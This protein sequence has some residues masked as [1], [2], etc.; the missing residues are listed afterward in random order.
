MMGVLFGFLIAIVVGMT[1]A[2][3]GSLTVPVLVLGCGLPMGEAVGT[4]MVFVT[5]VKLLSAPAYVLR[6]QFSS[7]TLIQLLAGG[8]PGVVAGAL[9][10]TGLHTQ[11]LEQAVLAT[12]GGTMA[13]L[14]MASLWV[15]RRAGPWT[16]KRDRS[17]W[18][19]WV[20]LPIGLEVGFSSA[21]ASALGCVALLSLTSLAP[22][23]I[24]GT[25]LLF[26]LGLS[27]AGSGLHLMLGKVNG[28]LV[29]QLIAGG[30]AGALIGPWLALQV[31]A[32]ALRRALL[33]ALSLFGAQL[34]W[35]GVAPLVS[36]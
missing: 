8:L 27:I 24:V 18:L 13:V 17:R 19:P 3:G 35:R 11:L 1:G 12:V 2:G 22:P 33:L 6:R 4:S 20:A 31:P 9:L 16:P 25:D 21:G 10:F 28:Q 15:S 34:F 32:P 26:G 36:W 29:E 14:A 7:R 30:V 5:M 23:V